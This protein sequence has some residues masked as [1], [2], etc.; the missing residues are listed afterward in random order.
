MI[1]DG[2]TQNVHSQ[3][4]KYLQDS[5]IKLLKLEKNVGQ[6][7]ALNRGLEL[8]DTPFIVQLDSDDKFFPHT[9]GVLVNEAR[10]Q[11]EDV[12]VFSGNMQ[13]IHEDDRGNLMFT[14]TNQGRPFTD[15]Y[16]FI[17][18]NTSLWPRF[19]RT[20][21]IRLVGGW[22]TDDP[23]GGRVME[24]KQVLL[25]LIERYR[26]HWVD[27][28]LYIHRR[29]PNN[30]TNQ[31]ALYAE[32]VEWS[33]RQALKRWGGTYEP[34][35]VTYGIGWKRLERLIPVS[36]GGQ[37]KPVPAAR[38]AVSPAKPPAKPQAAPAKPPASPAQG[39]GPR[40]AKKPPTPPANISP[41]GTQNAGPGTG[42]YTGP[43]TAPGTGPG[44]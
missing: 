3:I 5:R 21:A 1:D 31:I 16:D 41:Y 28:T 32:M 37:S 11:P 22:P 25:R 13:V 35:F 18:A 20:S 17:L 2:S 23:Y 33:I 15:K 24:D 14:T 44:T 6:S 34:V 7:Q 38:P 4:Q 19:Y 26:F 42:P 9:L 12:A 30:H 40:P 43:G 36:P 10:K 29:H 27:Q 39:T 8:V